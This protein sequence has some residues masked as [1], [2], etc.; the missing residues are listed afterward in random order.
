MTC[1]AWDGRTLAADRLS[2][3]SGLKAEVT[4]VRRIGGCLVGGSG[5][6]PLTRE[7]MD[8]FARG[9][10]P[11]NFPASLRD[12][13]CPSFL[14]VVTPDRKVFAY[15]NCPFPLEIESPHYALGSGRDFAMAA[16]HLG[17]DARKAVEVAIA[18]NNGCGGGIDSM[19]LA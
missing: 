10:D 18:L 9:A 3:S 6:A 14:L 2:V 11:T 19:E 15:E 17:H 8:W 4:K 5:D 12:E 1:I 13:K 7:Y 16:M